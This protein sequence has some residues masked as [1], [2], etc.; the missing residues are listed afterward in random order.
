[1]KLKLLLIL[2]QLILWSYSSE[3]AIKL[4]IGYSTIN[5]RI[6]PLWIAQEEGKIDAASVDTILSK[7]LEQ[8][9]FTVLGDPHKVDIPFVGVDIVS[10]R[11]F[12]AEQP[13]TVE[14]VRR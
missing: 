13:G 12:I 6:A 1:M 3:A 8:R 10:P 5:P 14:N 2:A 9:G 7:G 4:A 11:S